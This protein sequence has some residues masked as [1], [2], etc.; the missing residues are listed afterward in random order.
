MIDGDVIFD[1]GFIR[2]WKQAYAFLVGS[3]T[4]A[5]R[6]SPRRPRWPSAR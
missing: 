6:S 2:Y 3:T 5:R 1:A 4:A